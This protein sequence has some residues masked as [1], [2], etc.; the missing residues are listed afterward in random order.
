MSAGCRISKS[1]GISVVA[2]N[3]CGE[4]SC[5]GC[6]SRW[7]AVFTVRVPSTFER[8][9]L[10]QPQRDRFQVVIPKDRAVRLVPEGSLAED[11]SSLLAMQVS[12]SSS[13]ADAYLDLGSVIASNTQSSPLKSWFVF[14]QRVAGKPL[15]PSDGPFLAPSLLLERLDLG[16]FAGKTCVELSTLPRGVRVGLE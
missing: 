7:H 8:K 1:D 10:R 5:E 13:N 9:G 11:T 16:G 4:I 3:D 15:R 12:I 6:F 14:L 2:T